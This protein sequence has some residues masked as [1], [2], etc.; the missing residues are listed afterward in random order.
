MDLI[1]EIVLVAVGF[2]LLVFILPI[3]MSMADVFGTTAGWNPAVVTMFRV[4]IPIMY[5]IGSALY[6][7]PKIRK[8]E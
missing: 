1:H 2:I 5:I 7:I 6:L 8:G 3:G 4:I